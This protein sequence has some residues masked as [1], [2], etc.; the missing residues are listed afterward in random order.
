[1]PL[2]Y[3]QGIDE[4]T[5]ERDSTWAKETISALVPHERVTGSE[6]PA[7]DKFCLDVCLA[8]ISSTDPLPVE[9]A[10]DLNEFFVEGTLAVP[11]LL[12]NTVAT[13]TVPVGLTFKLR[14]V[15]CS[16]SIDGVCKI[17]KGATLVGIIRVGAGNKNGRFEYIPNRTFIAGEIITV[18]FI[19][20]G[21]IGPDVDVFIQARQF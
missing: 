18:T 13:H 5:I 3:K 14:N 20:A 4:H 7:E 9:D 10:G 19:S 21:T 16:T 15:Y 12:D 8:N 6:L 11:D 1:V 17:K 2:F